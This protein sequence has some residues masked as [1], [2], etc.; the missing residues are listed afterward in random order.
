MQSP[1]TASPAWMRWLS[2]QP[3]PPRTGIAYVAVRVVVYVAT[4][5][6]IVVLYSTKARGL[7]VAPPIGLLCAA[8]AWYLLGDTTLPPRRR[9]VL[10]AG[11]G[12]VLAQLTW[13]LGYWSTVPLVGGAALWLGFYVTSGVVEA[14]AGATLDR[15]VALEYAAVAAIGVAVVLAV[16]RPWSA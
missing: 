13:A 1:R 16:S 15:R 9:L 12:L 14:D 6:L 11:I 8:A 10:A 7:I 2:V 3:R 4:L 5:V